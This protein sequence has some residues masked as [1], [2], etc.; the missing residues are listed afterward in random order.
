VLKDPKI[1]IRLPLGGGEIDLSEFTTGVKGTFFVEFDF[2][3]DKDFDSLRVFYV[4]KAK[5]RK[6]DGQ[7]WGGGCKAAFNIKKYYRSHLQ[8]RKF[9][10]NT[11]DFRHLTTLGGHFVFSSKLKR[12]VKMA[13]VTFKDSKNPEYFCDFYTGKKKTESTP[14]N[15]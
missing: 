14:S 15:D 3:E 13:Q 2:E 12:Q 7:L 8:K 10:V 1:L 11:T 4:S 6:L 9:A 5:K